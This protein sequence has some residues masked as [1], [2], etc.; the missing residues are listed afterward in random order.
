MKPGTARI[1][2]KAAAAGV[3]K[4]AAGTTTTKPAAG[5]ATTKPADAK[6]AMGS[7]FFAGA[8]NGFA[9]IE[10]SH[11]PNGRVSLGE[12]NGCP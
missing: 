12:G 4:P 1:A 9:A 8:L 11:G 5:T 3:A 7:G 10:S 2:A 6:P